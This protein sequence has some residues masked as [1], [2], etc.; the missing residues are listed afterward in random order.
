MVVAL[1]DRLKAAFAD[2]PPHVQKA[3]LKQLLL[4]A[5]DLH[6]PDLH[7]KVYDESRGRWQVN[8]NHHWRLYFTIMDD[9]YR[10]DHLMPKP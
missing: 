7:T 1:T 4:L 2:A 8:I 6:H 9:T 5:S 10:I 3:L